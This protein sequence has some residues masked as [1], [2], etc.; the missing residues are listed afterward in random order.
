MGQALPQPHV[1]DSVIEIRQV[2][3]PEDFGAEF[4]PE[5]REAEARIREQLASKE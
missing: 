4:T 1:G 3:E 5:A 2:F